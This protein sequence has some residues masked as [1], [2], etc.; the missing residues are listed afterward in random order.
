MGVFRN[1]FDPAVSLSLTHWKHAGN[2][3]QLESDQCPVQLAATHLATVITYGML[4]T[5]AL[6]HSGKR[7]F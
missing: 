4:T 7:I 2:K 1:G 6:Q 3:R 5:H